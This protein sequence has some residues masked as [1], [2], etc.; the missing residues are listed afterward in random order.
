MKNLFLQELIVISVLLALS[1][2]DHAPA[3]LKTT[4]QPVHPTTAFGLEPK[5][6]PSPTTA[7]QPPEFRQIEPLKHEPVYNHVPTPHPDVSYKAE[8]KARFTPEYVSPPPR[9]PVPQYHTPEPE[10]APPPPHIPETGYAA[11][12]PHKPEHEYAP[13]T[14]YEPKSE[15]APPSPK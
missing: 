3:H 9:P 7:Y 6:S 4:L 12:A 10:Y 2:A 1:G 14:A 13:P 15:Y 5:A 8:P 11:P